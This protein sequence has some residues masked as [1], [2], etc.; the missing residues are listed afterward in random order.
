MRFTVPQFI[1]RE[2]P[3]IG[4][5][6]FR[7][8]IYIGVAGGISFLLY[9]SLGKTNFIAFVLIAIALLLVGAALA[10]VRIGGREL[11]T[12]AANFFRFFIS[13]KM[14]IWKKTEKPIEIMKKEIKKAGVE[15]APLKI[16]RSSQLNKLSTQIETKI[17]PQK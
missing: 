17:E 11:P 13:P 5:L 3:I 16:I 4:P 10:F 6:T 1:E 9:F 12:I 8:F 2:S 15:E 7:Q 14:Y